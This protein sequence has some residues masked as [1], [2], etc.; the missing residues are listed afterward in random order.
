MSGAEKL[1][2]K[3]LAEASR[4]AEAVLAEAREKAAA[5]LEQSKKEAAA[6]EEA[7]LAQARRQAEERKH[8]AQTIAELDARKEILAAKEKC[9]EETLAQVIERLRGL[10]PLQY[11]DLMYKMLLAA[12]Q[13]GEEEIIIDEE[14]R[15][16]FT[17]EFLRRVNTAIQRQ[18]KK[19]KLKIVAESRNLQGGFILRDKD[20][21]INNSF[22]ALL[23]MQRDELE[24]EIA[25]ILFSE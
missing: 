16:K 6:E 11:E 13:T 19:G 23:R 21:E 2:E 22:P 12:V 9:I 10:E 3:I 1:K 24:P 14:D 8:R 7:I 25:A 5:I 17:K 18:G 20:L 4:Q 15:S